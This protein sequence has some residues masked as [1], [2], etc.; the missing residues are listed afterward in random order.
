MHVLY[1]SFILSLLRNMPDVEALMQEWSP[2]FESALKEVSQ[3]T[4]VQQHTCI[5]MKNFP[6]PLLQLGLPTADLDCDLAQYTDIV[7]GQCHPPP[8]CCT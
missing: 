2:Q 5:L 1:V 7:C 3:T 4:C 6:L 8:Q